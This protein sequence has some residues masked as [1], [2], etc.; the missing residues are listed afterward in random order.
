MK[1]GTIRRDIYYI[2]RNVYGLCWTM[3][4]IGYDT[5]P[6]V[7]IG[8]GRCLTHSELTMLRMMHDDERR[9]WL[10]TVNYQAEIKFEHGLAVFA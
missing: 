2:G 10:K 1:I 3:Q 8:Y 5:A 6:P 9:E 4:P 7:I